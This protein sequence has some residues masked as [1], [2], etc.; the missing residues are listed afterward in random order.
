MLLTPLDEIFEIVTALARV[1]MAPN[2]SIPGSESEPPS[3]LYELAGDALDELMPHC[4]RLY[5]RASESSYIS[6]V[7]PASVCPC[8]T[9]SSGV[10]VLPR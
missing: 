7:L 4:K 9:D 1:R 3:V 8:L 2:A 10:C 6:F 5:S